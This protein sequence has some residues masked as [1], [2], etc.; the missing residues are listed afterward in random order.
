M[1]TGNSQ[2]HTRTPSNGSTVKLEKAAVITAQEY[3]EM[4]KKNRTE[5]NDLEQRVYQSLT[6]YEKTITDLNVELSTNE[7]KLW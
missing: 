3:G 6:F 1:Q 2:L 7:S 4:F 5:M